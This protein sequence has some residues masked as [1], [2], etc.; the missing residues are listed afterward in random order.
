[1]DAGAATRQGIVMQEQFAILPRRFQ[2]RGRLGLRV[3]GLA[4]MLLTSLFLTTPLISGVVQ[5][6][7]PVGSETAPPEPQYQAPQP[8]VAPQPLPQDDG[9]AN[10]DAPRTAPTVMAPPPG[11]PLPSQ[12][13]P[14]A[15]T[16][17]AAVQ[18]SQTRENSSGVGFTGSLSYG[19]GVAYRHLWGPMGLQVSGFGFISDRG[20]NTLAALGLAWHYRVLNF[21]QSSSRL[22]PSSSAL[23]LLLAG[24]YYQYK[25][26]TTS[27]MP[28]LTETG[29]TTS[30]FVTTTNI[31]NTR[32]VSVAAGL[33]FEFGAIQVPGFTLSV[34]LLLTAAFNQVGV[35]RF[36]LPLPAGSL[37]YNW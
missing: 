3:Q 28:S 26:T 8:A 16:H 30:S 36:I 31:D 27:T 5:A 20:D 18:R 4:T 7:Q 1:M 37:I 35:P 34:D 11:R 19:F 17:A 25:Q 23:R 9:Q 32:L 33:G 29:S 2:P 15:T 24:S 12:P 10:A 21:N 6:Q 22:M 14:P 13:Q